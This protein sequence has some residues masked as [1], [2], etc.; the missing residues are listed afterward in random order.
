MKYLLLILI[1]VSCGKQT[2]EVED[3]NHTMGGEAR[4]IIDWNL[5]EFDQIF[6]DSCEAE[7]ETS[8]E[9]D[10]CII[11]KISNFTDLLNKGINKGES[12]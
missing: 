2:L 6:R 5:E 10:Q 1:L 12:E 4:V 7:F 11:D 8:E 3:S 9:I